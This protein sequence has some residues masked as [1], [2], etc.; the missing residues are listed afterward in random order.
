MAGVGSEL[1]TYNWLM[2][3]SALVSYWRLTMQAA[4]DD[5]VPGGRCLVETQRTN[6][7]DLI[8]A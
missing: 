7:A 4:L 3:Q 1:A 2:K 5:N 6:R 8:H